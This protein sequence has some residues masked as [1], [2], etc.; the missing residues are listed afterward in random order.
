MRLVVA[1]FLPSFGYEDGISQPVIKGL[2]EKMPTGKEP[3]A[4]NPG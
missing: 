3:K 1:H 2:D 4:V